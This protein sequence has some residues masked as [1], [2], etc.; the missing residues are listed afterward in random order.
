MMPPFAPCGNYV[1]RIRSCYTTEMR[2]FPD[3]PDVL[4]TVDWYFTDDTAA[5]GNPGIAWIGTPNVFNSRNWYKGTINWP[6]LG[7][8]EGSPRTWRDGSFPVAMN[9]GGRV[10]EP[11]VWDNGVPFNQAVPDSPCGAPCQAFHG[12]PVLLSLLDGVGFRNLVQWP[13]GT[14]PFYVQDPVKPALWWT[15]THTLTPCGDTGASAFVHL[16]NGPPNFVSVQRGI[17]IRG[18]P[19]HR[20]GVWQM[21]T[22]NANAY[23]GRIVVLQT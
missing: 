6:M 11:D 19:N 18:V 21:G 5:T 17:I 20:S 3:R 13:F 1:S 9:G 23:P 7:E 22:A 2:F 4:T 10:G 8:V 15:I 14:R 16:S 12:P